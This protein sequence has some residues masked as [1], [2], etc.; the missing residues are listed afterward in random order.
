MSI[1]DLRNRLDIS[2]GNAQIFSADLFPSP[3][4]DFLSLAMAL[5]TLAIPGA[6][7]SALV[8]TVVAHNTG[9]SHVDES[10]VWSGHR[11]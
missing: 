5:S 8:L 11:L 10:Q 2:S 9:F 4:R 6:S 1:I 3:D 7:S